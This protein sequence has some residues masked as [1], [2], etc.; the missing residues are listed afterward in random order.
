MA[1][2]EISIS[3]PVGEQSIQSM[4]FMFLISTL[5]MSI[6]AIVPPLVNENVLTKITQSSLYYLLII[7][8]LIF[9]SGYLTLTRGDEIKS[10]LAVLRKSGKLLAI[11]VVLYIVGLFIFFLIV[12]TLFPAFQVTSPSPGAKVNQEI[13]VS[14]T[15]AI[16]STP[17]SI[18]VIDDNGTSYPQGQAIP[19]GQGSWILNKV[20]IGRTGMDTGKIFTIYAQT[21]DNAGK[22]VN[23]NNVA[24]A[25]Q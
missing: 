3:P 23:S 13:S 22:E 4:L 7:V 9:L 8:T 15:G 25:R 14:G 12:S 24:V 17:V 1:A 5:S 2:P 19:T 16:P 20:K 21:Q 11:F 18:W 6:V 10:G